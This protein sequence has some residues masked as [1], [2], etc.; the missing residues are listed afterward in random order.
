[1]RCN[2]LLCGKTADFTHTTTKENKCEACKNK[3]FDRE[4]ASWMRI[5]YPPAPSIVKSE[6]RNIYSI[7]K[8]RAFP[9]LFGVVAE[10]KE[11][12]VL[13]LAGE[14]LARN[15]CSALNKA[16]K[17]GA[18]N[19]LHSLERFSVDKRRENG[20]VWGDGTSSANTNY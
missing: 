17:K 3:R 18:E 9:D 8:V 5:Q 7:E 14:E 13:C 10:G 1:M 20:I 12:Y 15:V 2:T 16:Y 4:S 11:E 19:V 6:P